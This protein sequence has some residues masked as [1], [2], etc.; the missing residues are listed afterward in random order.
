MR[1][2]SGRSTSNTVPL[3]ETDALRRRRNPCSTTSA[4]SVTARCVRSQ[5]PTAATAISAAS[6]EQDR[7]GDGDDRPRGEEARR[8][9]EREDERAQQRTRERDPVPVRFEDGRIHGRFV[10]VA[11][12]ESLWK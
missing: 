2:S 7:S 9:R 3:S 10:L 1:P 11:N 4:F 5:R 6:R 12:R 8:A